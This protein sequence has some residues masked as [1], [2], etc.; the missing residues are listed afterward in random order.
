MTNTSSR[1]PWHLWLIGVIAVLFNSIG[2]FD[3]VMAMTQGAKY[4]ARAG[5][6]PEQIAH[7]QGMPGWM[8]A[9][10]AIGVWGAF[11]ASIL[12]LLR[13]KLAFPI[14]VLSLAAFLLSLVYTYI[15]TD[16]GAIMGRQMAITSAVIAILLLFFSWYAHA[17]GKRGVLR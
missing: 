13:R 10:W 1:A 11:L 6:T 8:T 4:M 9:V 2:I 17:M 7:Y 16:G 15:L 3:F 12:L 14:F 5:M